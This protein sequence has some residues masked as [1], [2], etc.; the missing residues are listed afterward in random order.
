MATFKAIVFTGG[1][2]LKQ[3]GTA[4]VKIRIYHNGTAQY[5]STEHYI[6]PELM[7]NDGLVSYL[8]PDS[9]ILN[10]DIAEQI[11]QLRK[12]A[13]K[14]GTTRIKK[15]TSSELKEQLLN[16]VDPESEYIDFVAFSK[17]II[18]KTVKRKTAEWYESSLN[19]FMYYKKTAKIDVKDINVR[20]LE[21]YIPNMKQVLGVN[22]HTAQHFTIARDITPYRVIF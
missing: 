21:D 9:E 10:Y 11:Q 1:K 20:N 2:H 7:G 17:E 13:I 6:K 14:L 12:V 18:S 19:S 3:D 8:L 4:N 15:M 5:I 16:G 22:H